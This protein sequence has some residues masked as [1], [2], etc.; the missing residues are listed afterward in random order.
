[1]KL[2][3]LLLIVVLLQC[4]LFVKETR[5]VVLTSQE[6]ELAGQLMLNPDYLAELQA[7]PLYRFSPNDLDAYLRF[8]H[9]YKPDLRDRIQYLARKNLTQPYEIY[10]LG[11]FPFEIYDLQPIFCQDRSDCVVFSEHTYAMALARNWQEFMVILQNIRYQDGRI[12]MLTRNHYTELDWDRNNSWLV[13]D[14]TE[15]IGGEYMQADTVV[16]DKR[17]FFKRMGIGQDLSP[18]TLVLSYI[19]AE[20]LT[21]VSS[22]LQPGDFINIVR[23]PE[24]GQPGSKYVGHV[25]LITRDSSGQLNMLHSTMPAVIEQP[26]HS[27]YFPYDQFNHNRHQT[28]LRTAEENRKIMA[29]NQ[30]IR[31]KYG[32]SRPE[33]F[34][35][36]KA[37][38][39]FFYGFKFLRLNP[40]PIQEL[41]K[42]SSSPDSLYIRYGVPMP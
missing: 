11:E 5:R 20:H 24:P 16:I 31:Q 26:L 3:G 12:G 41:K 15:E 8:I 37:L 28:N 25:G 21:K 39:P 18:D 6:K 10:L 1:M 2:F 4:S 29:H 38:L 42:R 14:I 22:R 40:D 9:L 17:N 23:G 7:K 13:T 32:D 33:K 34:K 19:P 27:V 36:T 35:K 30:S